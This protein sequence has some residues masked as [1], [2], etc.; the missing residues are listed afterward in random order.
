MIQNRPMENNFWRAVKIWDGDD[1]F[2]LGGG[3]SLK[4]LDIDIGL[5]KNHRVVAVN[6]AY[7]LGQFEA[8]FFG[9]RQWLIDHGDGL[10]DFGGLKVTIIKDHIGKPGIKVLKR[11]N[12]KYGIST[13]PGVLRWNY[14]SGACAINLAVLLGAG[15]II[16]L[17]FDMRKVEGRYNYHDEYSKPLKKNH[18]PYSRFLKSFP[19]IAR[20]LKEL[21]IECLN[22]TPGSALTEFPIVELE[23]VI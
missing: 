21:G 9:D 7:R 17:G 6:C 15:R 14:N 16:L 22:A 5:L 10:A 2:I 1:V 23:D 12:S 19:A 11:D 8:M 20:D 4:L 18:D 3:P 13:D